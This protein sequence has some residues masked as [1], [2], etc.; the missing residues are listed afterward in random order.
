[1]AWRR[2]LAAVGFGRAAQPDPG[3]EPV[4]VPGSDAQLQI[5]GPDD[6]DRRDE[7]AAVLRHPEVI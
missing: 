2:Y 3:H 5:H 1:M 6:A 7:R 4:G